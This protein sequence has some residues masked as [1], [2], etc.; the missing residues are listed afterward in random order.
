MRSTQGPAGTFFVDVYGAAALHLE[1]SRSLLVPTAQVKAPRELV[2][3]GTFQEA[4]RAKDRAAATD[5]PLDRKP[6][7]QD[8]R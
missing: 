7:S 3:V 8:T 5:S 1:R 6:G 2:P 4:R